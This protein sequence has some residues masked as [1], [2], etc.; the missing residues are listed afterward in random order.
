MAQKVI[1]A[2]DFDLYLNFDEIGVVYKV[3]TGANFSANIS[4]NDRRHRSVLY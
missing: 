4:G 3:E 2:R 1:A